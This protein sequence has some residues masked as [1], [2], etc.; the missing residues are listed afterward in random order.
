MI[1]QIFKSRTISDMRLAPNDKPGD[2]KNQWKKNRR[3]NSQPASEL[4]PL[5]FWKTSD[6]RDMR[7]ISS[8]ETIECQDT[9][10]DAAVDQDVGNAC[11]PWNNIEEKVL[12][13]GQ[14]RIAG[15]R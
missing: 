11:H 12:L 4:A 9:R 5:D 8:S 3:G 6:R 15:L 14:Q 13:F 2:Q 7:R 10:D 1:P